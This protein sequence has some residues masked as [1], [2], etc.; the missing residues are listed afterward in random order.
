MAAYTASKAGLLALTQSLSEE[1]KRDNIHVNLLLASTID[2]PANRTAMG[3]AAAASWVTPSDI[4]QATLFLCSVSRG[5]A[6]HGATL[7]VYATA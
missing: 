4:A 3:V 2:T 5:R 1:V 6:L 7:E